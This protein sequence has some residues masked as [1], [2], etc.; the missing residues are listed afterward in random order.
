MI[1]GRTPLL[2]VFIVAALA[3]ALG[4]D[5]NLGVYDEGVILTGAMRVAA[6]DVPHGDFYANYG[7][8]QFYVVAALFKLFGQYA[9]AE[10]AYDTLVRAGIV[11][12]CYGIAAGVAHRRIALAA[13]AAVFLWLYGLGYYG[14]PMLPVTLL[15][16]AA[17]ALVQPSLAGTGSA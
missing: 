4:M 10:R 13:A 11:A 1:R 3:M 9:I 17:A 2:L 15:S 12:M 16:L 8:G 14:Y 5:R 7:P 6:G